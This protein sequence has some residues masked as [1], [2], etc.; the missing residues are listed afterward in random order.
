P[1]GPDRLRATVA[2]GPVAGFEAAGLVEPE[3]VSWA[4]EEIDGVGGEVHGRLY[5]SSRRSRLKQPG[6]GA[7]AAHPLILWVHGGPTGQTLAGW[8]PRSSFFLD[9]GWNVLQVDPRG[10]TGWGRAY[11]RALNGRWGDLDVDD[12]AAGIRAAGERG[13]GDP[14][15]IAIMGGSS[16]GLAVL[17]VLIRH[18]QL[19]AAGVDLYGVSDLFS[20]DETTHRFEAHYNDI[21]VGPL[22]AAAA[23]WRDRSPVT[24]LDRIRAPLLVLHG[25]ADDSVVPAQ[26]EAVVAG[27]ERRGATVEHHWYEGEGHGWSRPETVEDELVRTE[28]FLSRH[29]LRGQQ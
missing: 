10:S 13:W 29:V 19:C 23:T 4:G 11:A 24:H 2:R 5:R 3:P 12:I 20:L 9:R 27:L 28:A 18:P 6:V 25:T 8:H 16:G 26:S 22:P 15:R 21:L 17:G 1:G 7:D 14:G